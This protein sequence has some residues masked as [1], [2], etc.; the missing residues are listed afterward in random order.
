MLGTVIIT[1][2]CNNPS[3]NSKQETKETIPIDICKCLTEPGNSEYM[4]QNAEACDKTISREIGVAD[5]RKVNM[6]YDK[7]ASKKFD[8]LIFKCT[9][10]RPNI[11]TVEGTY[12]YKDNSVEILIT[13]SGSFWRGKTIMITGFGSDYDDQNAQY[14]NGI[15][16]GKDLYESSGMVKIG[17][18]D[19]NSLT[20]AVGDQR[21][22]L[23]K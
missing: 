20:T 21:V 22:T 8:D 1:L 12:S 6:K 2:S 18:V 10:Q 23:S 3:S 16:K 17:Y 4:I 13:I 9:G 7:A 5:W 11:E 19:G 15:V 14:D